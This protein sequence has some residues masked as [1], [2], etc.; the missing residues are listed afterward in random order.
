MK[1]RESSAANNVGRR[2]E[3]G[4]IERSDR[5]TLLAI[6]ESIARD[7]PL[8]NLFNDIAPLFQQLTSCD[9]LNFSLYDPTRNSFIARLWEK[10]QGTVEQE[11]P[12]TADLPCYWVWHRQEP[13]L[14]SDL[15]GETRFGDSALELISLGLLSYAAFSLS[16]ADSH[17]GTL[18]FGSRT[19]RWENPSDAGFLSRLA[20]LL[21][22]ALERQDLRQQL[23]KTRGRQQRYGETDF[24][25]PPIDAIIGNSPSLRAVLKSAAVVAKTAEIV[26]QQTIDIPRI[27][28]VPRGEVKSGFRPF[29]LDL[30]GM[31]Y[32]APNET[33]WAAHL[34]T[35]QI[36][37][38]GLQR[39]VAAQLVGRC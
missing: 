15:R 2:E 38:I 23:R 26:V 6:T 24:E 4:D 14:I 35:G 1:E 34:R 30:S 19:P 37:R 11:K 10:G 7:Q 31:Q 36:E 18:G 22:L 21:A 32:E 33:L 5:E 29:T 12:S 9:I 28:V 13:I 8:A 17:Y 20:R 39:N 27:L 25:Q 3:L 16:A